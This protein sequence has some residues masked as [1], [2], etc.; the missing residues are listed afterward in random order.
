[1]PVRPD[2]RRDYGE[3]RFIGLGAMPRPSGPPMIV[4]LIL[5]HAVL[6]FVS[7]PRARRNA[8]KS[9]TI[10]KP[11]TSRRS[12]TDWARLDRMQDKDIDCS[13]IPATTRASW[14]GAKV[15]GAATA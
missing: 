15:R 11:S 9:K 7:S 13:D 1:M 6:E 14:K 3:D 12:R 4:V 5:P 8:V 2:R 10:T